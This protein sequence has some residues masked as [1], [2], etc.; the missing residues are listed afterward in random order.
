[1]TLQKMRSLQHALLFKADSTHNWQ[2]HIFI[3]IRTSSTLE[4]TKLI[5]LK[6]K[7][8]KTSE[9]FDAQKQAFVVSK[10]QCQF[11]PIKH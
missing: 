4:G 7:K 10:Q 6:Y 1:M 3:V 2:R 11:N 8:S 5:S 9:G